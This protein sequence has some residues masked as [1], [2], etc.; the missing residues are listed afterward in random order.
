MRHSYFHTFR[1]NFTHPRFRGAAMPPAAALE[2]FVAERLVR[3]RRGDLPPRAFLEAY[4]DLNECIPAGQRVVI[5]KLFNN[6]LDN[7]EVH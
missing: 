1:P 3:L 5:E 6:F 7:L 4:R 2:R